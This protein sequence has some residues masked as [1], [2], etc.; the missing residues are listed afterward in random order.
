MANLKCLISNPE[1]TH[2]AAATCQKVAKGN[3]VIFAESN[4][5]C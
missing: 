3:V 1:L 5:I 4:K 2:T